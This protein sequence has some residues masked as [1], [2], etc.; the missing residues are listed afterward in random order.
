MTEIRCNHADP[1]QALSTRG[2]GVPLRQT[3]Y[4]ASRI[5]ALLIVML[6]APSISANPGRSGMAPPSLLGMSLHQAQRTDFFTFFHLVETQRRKASDKQ[7][8]IITFKPAS[9]AFQP[10]VTVQ[11]SVSSQGKIIKMELFLARSFIEDRHERGF[12]SDIAQSLIIAAVPTGERPAV[13]TL[14]REIEYNRGANLQSQVDPRELVE[15]C[16]DQKK[17]N[18]AVAEKTIY[19]G[20]PKKIPKEASPA[21]LTYWGKQDVYE[22]KLHGGRLYLKNTKPNNEDWLQIQI[23]LTP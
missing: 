4:L 14:I 13:E 10:V 19:L 2:L 7:T 1:V 18:E 6:H 21:Y 20:F 8:E 15:K 22:Q 23:S 3:C 5:V 11:A 17:C 12:A 16:K 9:E